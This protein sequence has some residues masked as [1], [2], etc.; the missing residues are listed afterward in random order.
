MD[1]LPDLKPYAG[2]WV[3]LHRGEVLEHGT[4]LQGIVDR[5]R[6]QGIQR[7]RVL[8]VEGATPKR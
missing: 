2:E 6:A 8:F 3:V 4:E 5:A 7:P 1:D